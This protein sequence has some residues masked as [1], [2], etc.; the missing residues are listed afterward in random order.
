MLSQLMAIKRRR[1][2]SAR[3]RVAEASVKLQE[4][5]LRK[6]AL[7]QEQKTLRVAWRESNMQSHL[8]G[9]HQMRVTQESL[10]HWFHKDIKLGEQQLQVVR[11]IT[12]LEDWQAQ[13]KALLARARIEQEKL[14]W[15]L[16]Q[17]Q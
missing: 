6:S 15:L 7:R 12:E 9:E 17:M 14:A 13:Q 4:Q 8:V 11:T 5:E 2:Q 10:N 3:Q 16:E 1:E